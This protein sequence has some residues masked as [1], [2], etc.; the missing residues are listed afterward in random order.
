M[1]ATGYDFTID[2]FEIDFFIILNQEL[3]GCMRRCTRDIDPK[4]SILF[5]RQIFKEKNC[6]PFISP[7]CSRAFL[8]SNDAKTSPA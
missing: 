5:W 4:S 7:D 2:P 1:C 6:I 8:A 3:R